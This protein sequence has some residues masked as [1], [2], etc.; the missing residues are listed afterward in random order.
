VR[1]NR[2]EMS[3]VWNS[4][5]KEWFMVVLKIKIIILYYTN[6]QLYPSGCEFTCQSMA[7]ASFH[8]F[9]L[10]RATWK[11]TLMYSFYINIYINIF[12]HVHLTDDN[13]NN[14]KT[15]FMMITKHINIFRH[16]YMHYFKWWSIW[17]ILHWIILIC[18]CII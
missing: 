2:Q 8:L 17:I 5:Q 14:F 1:L 9:L 12:R 11:W 3:F 7:C 18:L 6:I 4:F 10:F 15:N 16:R 13:T